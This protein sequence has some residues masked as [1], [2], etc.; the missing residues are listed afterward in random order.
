VN[1]YGSAYWGF[2]SGAFV[3]LNDGEC[4][5]S[6][7]HEWF[8]FWAFKICHV[9]MLTEEV[10]LSALTTFEGHPNAQN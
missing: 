4:A 5:W 1:L 2:Y 8:K 3:H 9:E 7:L 6:W 10:A